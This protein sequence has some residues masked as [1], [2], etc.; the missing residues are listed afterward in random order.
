VRKLAKSAAIW[1]PK[2]EAAACIVNE[3]SFKLEQTNEKIRG[4]YCD[5]NLLQHMANW[6]N[7]C[8]L[9]M[10]IADTLSPHAMT[11]P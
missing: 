2:Y 9:W 7:I 5:E 6:S 4:I 8:T 1:Y 3:L 10:V 11:S